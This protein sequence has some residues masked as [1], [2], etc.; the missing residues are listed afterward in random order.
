MT[1]RAGRLKHR[2]RVQTATTSRGATGQPVTTWTT[3]ATVWAYVEP[4]KG[5]ERIAAQGVQAKL[6][7]RVHLRYNAYPALTTAMRLL[8]GTRI[9]EITAVVNRYEAD[10]EIVCDCVEVL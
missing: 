4:V 5:D 6:S 2:V 1:M 3:A 7:H 10:K 9:F 8:Y